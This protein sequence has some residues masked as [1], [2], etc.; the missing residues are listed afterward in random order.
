MSILMS[1]HCDTRTL[2]QKLEKHTYFKMCASPYPTY[3]QIIIYV[4]PCYPYIINSYIAAIVLAKTSDP[5]PTAQAVGK[6]LD[7]SAGM[8]KKSAL[9]FYV[10][11]GVIVHA[12]GEIPVL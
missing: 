8:P 1:S 5:N 12:L 2:P 10:F 9:G 11:W 3:S 6:L 7:S 4:F